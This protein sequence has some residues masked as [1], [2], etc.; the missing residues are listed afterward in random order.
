MKTYQVVL[1]LLLISFVLLAGLSLP[2][3]NRLLQTNSDPTPTATPKVE[4]AALERESGDTIGLIYGAS[5]ILIIILGGLFIQM[6]V[7]KPGSLE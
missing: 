2:T 7:N 4:K 3:N 1:M 6:L 5:L